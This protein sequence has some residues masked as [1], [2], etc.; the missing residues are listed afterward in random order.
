MTQ[1]IFDKIVIKWI[2]NKSCQIWTLLYVSHC[3][4]ETRS[5]RSRG[6]ELFN[7]RGYPRLPPVD[8][9]VNFEAE[10]EPLPPSI[11]PFDSARGPPTEKAS[12]SFV[13][14]RRR[15]TNTVFL[16]MGPAPLEAMARQP[17][18]IGT[19]SS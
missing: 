7:A 5:K 11:S 2:F 14:H 18:E 3:T 8:F 6:F 10:P 13:S 19:V 15:G 17:L 12:V 4:R 1:S 9:E 16:Q